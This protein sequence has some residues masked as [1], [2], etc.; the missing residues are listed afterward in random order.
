MSIIIETQLTPRILSIE[1]IGQLL[2]GCN[3]VIC[4]YLLIGQP[5]SCS[6]YAHGL[7]VPLFKALSEPPQEILRIGWC[8]SQRCVRV[9]VQNFRMK[10]LD[11]AV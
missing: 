6:C 4:L 10:P 5:E 2:A 11:H 8:E 9:F 1:N 7:F 3:R